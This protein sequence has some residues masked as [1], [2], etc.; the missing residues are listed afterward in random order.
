[1]NSV[2]ASVIFNHFTSKRGYS[3]NSFDMSLQKLLPYHLY[4]IQ[5]SNSDSR[6]GWLL[7]NT[8]GANLLSVSISYRERRWGSREAVGMYPRGMRLMIQ[9]RSR[10]ISLATACQTLAYFSRSSPLLDFGARALPQLQHPF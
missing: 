7:W 9:W 8:N 3:I 6:Y 1:M 5:S 10:F 4:H 2:A